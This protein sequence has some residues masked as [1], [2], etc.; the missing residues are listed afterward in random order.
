M[1]SHD[2]WMPVTIYQFQI[3]ISISTIIVLFVVKT[4]GISN[5]LQNSHYITNTW[6]I[7]LV[8]KTMKIKT[9]QMTLALLFALMTASRIHH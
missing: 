4:I 6:V 2:F 5:Y 8:Q 1:Q 7:V 9:Y 3:I